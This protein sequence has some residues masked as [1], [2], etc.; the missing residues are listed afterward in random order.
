MYRR[1]FHLLGAALCVVSLGSCTCLSLAFKNL[2]EKNV[3][4]K[5]VEPYA[6]Y[7]V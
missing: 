4:Y 5:P 1:L 7:R 3:I 2:G 6:F